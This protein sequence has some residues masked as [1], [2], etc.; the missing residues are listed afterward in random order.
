MILLVDSGPDAQSDLGPRCPH[1]SDD[2]FSHGTALLISSELFKFFTSNAVYL[3][4]VLL[5]SSSECFVHM[6]IKHGCQVIGKQV[7]CLHSS[8]Q[9]VL[10]ACNKLKINN[11]AN[12]LIKPVWVYRCWLKGSSLSE[13]RK[14]FANSKESSDQRM[15]LRSLIRQIH[16][17]SF[18][19]K[20]M[21]KHYVLSEGISVPTEV[22]LQ[23]AKT[24]ISIAG[25]SVGSK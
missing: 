17:E 18:F 21:Q 8:W 10:N 24:C 7:K 6:F 20:P 1:M 12:T 25:H 11:F 4:S 23:P 2:T 19:F 5:E 3:I 22:H 14:T 9:C 16:R 15:H 13:P